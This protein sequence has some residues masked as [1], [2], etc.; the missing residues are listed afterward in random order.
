[1][2][3]EMLGPE[4][5]AELASWWRQAFEALGTGTADPATN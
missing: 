4:E 3:H 5:E 2:T 1:M